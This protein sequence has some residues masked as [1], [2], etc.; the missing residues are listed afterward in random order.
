[1]TANA[2]NISSS[3]SP[4]AF[5]SG[6]IELDNTP[7][8]RLYCHIPT[9]QSIGH[10]IPTFSS[11]S[12]RVLLLTLSFRQDTHHTQLWNSQRQS[13]P[14]R[15]GERSARFCR[16]GPQLLEVSTEHSNVGR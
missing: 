8:F 12:Y 1:M 16:Q 4:H 2:Y 5:I 11:D 6:P 10:S 7:A 3:S 14:R 13:D 9:I 15:N